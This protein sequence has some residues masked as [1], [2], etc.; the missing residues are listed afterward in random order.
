MWN[1]STVFATEIKTS[2]LM[3]KCTLRI[4]EGKEEVK[5]MKVFGNKGK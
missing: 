5:V 1:N 4:S 2:Y 3:K